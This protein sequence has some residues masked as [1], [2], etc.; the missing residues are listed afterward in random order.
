MKLS[1]IT[2][3]RV[4]YESEVDALTIPTGEGEIGILP[5]HIPLLTLVAAG[6]LDATSGGK[7]ES[8]TIAD[9]FAEVVGEKIT[10]LTDQA[11]DVDAIDPEEVEKARARAKAELD[12]AVEQ[13]FDESEIERLQGSYRF[14]LAQQLAKGRRRY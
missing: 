10:I 5:G 3:E 1:I 4:A 12:A 6:T 13:N 2:P 8:L 9:G 7:T 14:A 11:I